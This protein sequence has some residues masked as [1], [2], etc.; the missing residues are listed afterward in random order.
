[1]ILPT[2][3]PR[4]RVI[5]P[6]SPYFGKDLDISMRY[7]DH[8]HTGSSPDLYFCDTDSGTARFLSTQID[9]ELYKYE[10][11]RWETERLGAHV[12][13]T[14]YVSR[15]G[16]GSFS[17]GFNYKSLHTITAIYSC[18]SVD[19]DGGLANVF[20]PDVIVVKLCPFCGAYGNGN[21]IIE[22]VTN[23]RDGDTY[24]PTGK[25]GHGK[26]ILCLGCG[27]ASQNCYSNSIDESISDA[28]AAWNLRV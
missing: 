4:I 20:R 5:D 17:H 6:T 14:V 24:V 3:K 21:Q 19:L 15:Y 9:Q 7:L 10:Q 16:S 22:N 28:V 26:R 13:D 23:F 27:A 25:D 2:W 18:G 8:L 12:G 1:M 11:I